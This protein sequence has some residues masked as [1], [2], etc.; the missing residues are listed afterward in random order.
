MRKRAKERSTAKAGRSGGG[1]SSRAP[2]KAAPAATP[3]KCEALVTVVNKRGLH[4][5][6]AAKF[7]KLAGDYAAE[8]RVTA[9]KG[10]LAGSA[11]VSGRS[12]MGLMM[13]AAGPGC[14]LHIEAE[15][16]DAADA[17]DALTKLIERGFEED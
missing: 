14:T 5:R 9:A 2:G 4:A 10:G 3:R 17:L 7:V 1:A 8:I 12:I 11:V 15:G 13:L 16:S 6:A